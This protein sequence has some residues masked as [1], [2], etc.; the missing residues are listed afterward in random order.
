MG[1]ADFGDGLSLSSSSAHSLPALRMTL[2]C[3]L[4]VSPHTDGFSDLES[5]RSAGVA[6]SPTTVVDASVGE[7]PVDAVASA[8]HMLVHNEDSADSADN[9]G[10]RTAPAQLG[11]P[12]QPLLRPEGT[13]AGAQAHGGSSDES[14]ASVAAAS[15]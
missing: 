14:I 1:S 5:H 9:I 2:Q 8:V 13:P 3:E 4:A 15:L 12:N 10:S 6:L 7:A 11:N